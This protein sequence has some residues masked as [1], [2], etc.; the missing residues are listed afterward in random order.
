MS[1]SGTVARGLAGSNSATMAAATGARSPVETRPAPTLPFSYLLVAVLLYLGWSNR[2]AGFLTPEEGLGYGLGIIGTC[3]MAMLLLYPMRKWLR[4]MRH[5]GRL[6]GWFRVHMALGILGP[7]AIAFHCNFHLGSL[8]ATVALLS[9]TIVVA[10]GVAGR[11]LYSKIHHGLYGSRAT[12]DELRGTL[13][14]DE[15]HLLADLAGAPGFR[16]RL[17][18]FEA[19]AFAERRGIVRR[20]AHLVILPVRT[21][22]ERR[23]LSDC[24]SQ[25]IKEQA[26][27][28]NWNWAE[29][30]R[31]KRQARRH[32]RAHLT[33]IRKVAV[34]G[35]YEG[36][37][38]LWHVLHL[39]LFLVLLVAA[40]IHIVAVHRY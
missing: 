10:S 22:R 36:V 21:R 40:S 9:M 27:E 35:F 18:A 5:W 30:R 3:L 34:F 32:L 23:L 14:R 1:A 15:E 6:R 11:Y 12:L 31:R 24:I 7:L 20:V 33:A 39:P 19:Y 38:A 13:G 28:N 29:R 4:S 26:G 2:D 8:N 17:A 37:F 25:T 16:D